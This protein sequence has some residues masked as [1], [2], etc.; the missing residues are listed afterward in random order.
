MIFF[1]GKNNEIWAINVDGSNA[2]TVI[3]DKKFQAMWPWVGEMVAYFLLQ[4]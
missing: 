1:A 4:P 3:G 2:H